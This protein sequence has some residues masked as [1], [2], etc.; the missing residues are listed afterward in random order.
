M[1]RQRN[2]SETIQERSINVP[3]EKATYLLEISKLS[4]EALAIL[5]SKSG[6]PGIEQKLKTY[7]ALI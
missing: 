5:A 3:S 1:A 6:K 2:P 4:V 7:Q